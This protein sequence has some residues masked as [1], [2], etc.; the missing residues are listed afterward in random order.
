MNPPF[1]TGPFPSRLVAALLALPS[2]PSQEQEA[3]KTEITEG[4]P[5][6]E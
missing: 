4:S 6:F 1:T 5:D 2:L 3:P